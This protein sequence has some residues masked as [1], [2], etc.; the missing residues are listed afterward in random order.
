MQIS[1]FDFV[2]LTQDTNVLP[3]QSDD[4]DLNNFLMVFFD[5]SENSKNKKSRPLI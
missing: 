2:Q 5:F 4:N 1:D 3:F